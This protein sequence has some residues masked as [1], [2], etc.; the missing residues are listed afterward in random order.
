MRS[1]RSTTLRLLRRRSTRAFTAVE[2][3]LSVAIG[4]VVAVIGFSGLRLFD[5]ELP[6]KSVSRRFSHA[7]S[8]ARSFAI[9]R[10]GF[11]QVGIDL[12]NGSFWIDQINDPNAPPPDPLDDKYRPKIVSPEGIDDRVA[13]NGLRFGG[14]PIL[15]STG[16]QTILFRPDGSADADVRIEFH[17][18]AADPAIDANIFTVRVYGPS[19]LNRVFPF[20]RI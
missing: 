16:I 10:N 13:V 9:A 7:L 6:A 19:G 20:Q 17:Q 15:Q 8:T 3:M 18:V 14:N 11:Y 1:R 12:D 5:A 4:L 2:I